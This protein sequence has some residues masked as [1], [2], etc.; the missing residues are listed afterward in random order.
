MCDP[1]LRL[2]IFNVQLR[3]NAASEGLDQDGYTKP[4]TSS[5]RGAHLRKQHT[6]S[7]RTCHQVALFRVFSDFNF[8]GAP[9]IPG[10]NVRSTPRLPWPRPK[11]SE[12]RRSRRAFE[13]AR[14]CVTNGAPLGKSESR[15]WRGLAFV[16]L[17]ALLA[18]T[19]FWYAHWRFSQIHR[20][21]VAGLS[22]T[23]PGQPFDILLVG[24]DSRQFVENSGEA[25]S[26]A[27]GLVRR[28]PAQ[29]RHHHR[30]NRSCNTPS[31]VALDS[32]STRS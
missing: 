11:R 14:R 26:F 21:K 8:T 3:I 30:P 6:F 32:R 24:S 16:A 25:G 19:V 1:L 28:R 23:K 22:P 20:E 18:G 17:F 2:P 7:A 10:Q 12:Q 4:H 15:Y 27:I 29:R 13:P 31:E 9:C 5:W